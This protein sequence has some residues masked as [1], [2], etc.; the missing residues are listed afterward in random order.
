MPFGLLYSCSQQVPAFIS[1]GATHHTDARDLYQR[2]REQHKMYVLI[3]SIAVVP[4]IS[5]YEKNSVRYCHKC[6][7]VFIQSTGYSCQILIKPV[8][9]RQIF[10]EYSS[11][12]FHENPSSWRRNIPGGLTNGQ[13]DMMK[14]VVVLRNFANAPKNQSVNAVQGNNRSLF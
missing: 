11:I 8:F 10:E 4:N 3:F 12:K 13:R 1:R 5:R 9:S 6:R 2:R 14:L 7:L